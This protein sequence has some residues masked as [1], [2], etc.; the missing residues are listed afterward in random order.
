MLF[1]TL[2]SR[3]GIRSDACAGELTADKFEVHHED[4]CTWD[5]RS[6]NAETR[7]YR[8]LRELRQGVRLA[9]ACRPCNG[10]LNQAT[11]G[12][13]EEREAA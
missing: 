3:C 7:L 2:G 5:Q 13:R 9:A 8:Y 4:G 11:Y 6:V 12:T 10:A 1:A